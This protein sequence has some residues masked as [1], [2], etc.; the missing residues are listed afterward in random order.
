MARPAQKAD[1]GIRVSVRVT[2]KAGRDAVAG[3]SRDD[4]G[5]YR[6]LVKVSAPPADG[7]ANA[8]VTAVVAKA[9]GVAK[10]Y[11]RILRGDTGREKLLLIE[12][13]AEMLEARFAELERNSA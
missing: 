6:L 4:A 10:S 11:V 2:P 12:G 5:Q 8:A 1:G 7:A 3:A 13:D 9:F